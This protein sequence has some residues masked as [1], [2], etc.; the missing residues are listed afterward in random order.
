M[1]VYNGG[2]SHVQFG[3]VH[4]QLAQSIHLSTRPPQEILDLPRG[5]SAGCTYARAYS[6]C[7]H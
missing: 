4:M 1:I 5:R 7:C 3:K 6:H 2:A